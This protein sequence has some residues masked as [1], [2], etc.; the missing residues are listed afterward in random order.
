MTNDSKSSR[1]TGRGAGRGATKAKPRVV[2]SRVG[3][4]GSV[5]STTTT[6]KLGRSPV[7]PVAKLH[8]AQGQFM[9]KTTRKKD[10]VATHGQCLDVMDQVQKEFEQALQ[11]MDDERAHEFQAMQRLHEEKARETSKL[12]QAITAKDKVLED[13][14][15][16]EKELCRMK[17]QQESL[18][19]TRQDQVS[20]NDIQPVLR[21]THGELL[22]AT[23]QLWNTI[24]ALQS[25]RPVPLLP[26]SEVMHVTWPNQN[27]TLENLGHNALPGFSTSSNYPFTQQVA[28]PANQYESIV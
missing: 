23:T 28:I 18:E 27:A 13:N 17:Q 25:G 14:Q 8:K 12:Q 22:S 19:A 26:S 20:W 11:K 2:G 5:R 16:L 3:S 10:H 9:T 6:S 15:R 21:Q 4:P 1:G 24:D 7:S